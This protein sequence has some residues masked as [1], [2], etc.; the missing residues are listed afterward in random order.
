[1][2]QRPLKTSAFY[3]VKTSLTPAWVGSLKLD[4]DNINTTFRYPCK[5]GKSMV[6][7]FISCGLPQLEHRRQALSAG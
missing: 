5:Q 7:A 2:Q 6:N 4:Y 1:M 3:S